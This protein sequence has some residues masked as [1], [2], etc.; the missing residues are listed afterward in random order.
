MW[1]QFFKALVLMGFSFGVYVG[2]SEVNFEEGVGPVCSQLR[3]AHGSPACKHTDDGYQKFSYPTTILGRVDLLF[4]VDNSGSMSAEQRNMAKNFTRFLADLESLG[5]ESIS[6]QIGIITTDVTRNA[7]KLLTF[8]NKNNIISNDASNPYYAEN[9]GALFQETIQRQETLDCESSGFNPAKCPSG[10]ES[11]IKAVNSF[12][13]KGYN[14]FFRDHSFFSIIIISD[15]DENSRG[16]NLK[17]YNL[18]E[19]L[20]S[21]V[22]L[23]VSPNKAFSV[24]AI[25]VMPDDSK[26]AKCLEEQNALCGKYYR[27]NSLREPVKECSL[28]E[29]IKDKNCYRA[30]CA[31]PAN[32]YAKLVEPTEKLKKG[33]GLSPGIMSDI[34][35]SQY[36]SPIGLGLIARSLKTYREQ[37]PLYCV[38]VD[39]KIEV[40]LASK[41]NRYKPY[42]GKVTRHGKTLKF[43]PELP[44]GTEVQLAYKCLRSI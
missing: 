39:S 19:T 10:K 14:Y 38:P 12:L 8:G 11:G 30:P 7:G 22:G 16:K 4:V 31:H 41:T 1:G 6:Y 17:E 27:K 18:P 20:V 15:E 36:Y 26:G 33:T 3:R 24:N 32:T 34:C 29:I 40:S 25:V 44:R 37:L 5:R 28:K 23:Q 43:T 13:D 35:A 42:S 21:K 2:C 9:A